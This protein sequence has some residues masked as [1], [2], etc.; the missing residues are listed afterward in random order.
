M[1]TTTGMSTKNKL[2]LGAM[3]GVLCAAGALAAVP[4]NA[5]TPGCAPHCIQVFSARYGSPTDPR[6]VETVYRGTA[7]VGTP[8]ILAPPSTT[9]PAGDIIVSAAG[10]VTSFYEIGMVSAAINE[11]YGPLD[12]V[13]LEY[14]PNGVPTG[15]CSGL[16]GKPHQN[17]GLT[18]QPCDTPGSTVFILDV[19]DSPSTAP[20]Y[21]PIVMGNTT[22]FRHPFA[23][24]LVGNPAHKRVPQIKIKRLRGNPDH[25]CRN[26]LWSANVLN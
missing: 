6:F 16:P 25:V 4:A 15:L 11:H 18:L 5:A 17:S 9:D 8:A 12:A 2:T 13:Q 19:T 21:F 10:T 26:Q 1:W 14:A 20:L 7:A 23:M 24:T 22:N 3:G